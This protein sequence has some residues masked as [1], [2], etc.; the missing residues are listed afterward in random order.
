MKTLA[1][2]ADKFQLPGSWNELTPDQLLRVGQL[3]TTQR[4]PADFKLKV[5]LK[6]TGLTVMPRRE[7]LI[8]DEP[9]Y[10]LQSHNRKIH[11]VSLAALNEV[12]EAIDFMFEIDSK[13]TPQQWTLC[14]RLT[15][16]I[17]GPLK[18]SRGMWYGPADYL[19]N[20]ITEEYI[21]AEVSLYRY[22]ET[23]RVNYLDMLVAA[24]WRPVATS[25]TST[26]V[27]EPFDDG[28]V[29]SRAVIASMLPAEAKNAVLMF[30]EGCRKALN[31]KFK[32]ASSGKSKADKDI[33]MQFMRMVSGLANNDV[34]KQEQVRR[35]P[36]MDTLITIDELARQ[37]QE[38]EQKMKKQRK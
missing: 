16:N 10:Y 21:R 6:V 34:T 23:H 12:C 36:L 3:S 22:Y 35:A 25:P 11:L 38:L 26:D 14:S 19:S 29:A 8:N 5:L 20:L 4:S 13:S 31:A 32:S 24:L 33:F 18:T 7:V 37:Q 1:I 2:N 28:A 9:H 30:Y 27:R 17:I 15:R